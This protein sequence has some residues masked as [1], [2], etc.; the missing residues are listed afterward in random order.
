METRSGSPVPSLAGSTTSVSSGCTVYI[1]DQFV[2]EDK[3]EMR[4]NRMFSSANPNPNPNSNP[5]CGWSL[6]WRLGQWIVEN[7]PC[8][9]KDVST[10]TLWRD[11]ALT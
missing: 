4:L 11:Y 1:D 5:S 6:S 8:E 3:L 10:R 2:N 7:A 9:L